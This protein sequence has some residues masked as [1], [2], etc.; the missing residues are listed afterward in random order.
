MPLPTPSSADVQAIAQDAG[1]PAL[2]NVLITDRYHRLAEAM[3]LRIG[4]DVINWCT[5]GCWASKTAGQFIRGE[6]VPSAFRALVGRHG[7]LATAAD[8]IAASAQIRADSGT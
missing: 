5:M 4:G 1:N 3:R 7:G 6:E 2:R 8:A